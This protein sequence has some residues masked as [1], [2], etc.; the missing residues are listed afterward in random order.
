MDDP[1]QHGRNRLTAALQRDYGR[2]VR[3]AGRHLAAGIQDHD[4]EDVLSDVVVRLLERADL[5]AEVENVTAYL[6]TALGHRIADLFRRRREQPLPDRD[7][8]TLAAAPEDV[9]QRLEISQ[10]LSLLSTAERAVWLAVELE[11]ATFRELARLWDVPVGT[12]LSRKSRATKALRRM[13]GEDRDGAAQAPA[14]RRRG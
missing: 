6:F 5:L 10:A 11:G 12:L 2:L 7:D 8:A 9:Q 14:K 4:A 3:F 1:F 13:L